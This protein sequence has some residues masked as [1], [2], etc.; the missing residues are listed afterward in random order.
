MTTL[1]IGAAEGA[2]AGLSNVWDTVGASLDTARTAIDGVDLKVTY[3]SD[4]GDQVHAGFSAVSASFQALLKGGVD[5]AKEGAE[6]LR[7]IEADFNQVNNAAVDNLTGL[8]PG[9]GGGGFGGGGLPLDAP[10]ATP[11]LPSLEPEMQTPGEGGPGEGDGVGE[12]AAL[13]VEAIDP[14]ELTPEQLEAYNNSLARDEAHGQTISTVEELLA[15]NL[16]TNTLSEGGGSAI[17]IKQVWNPQS[18]GY[19]WIASLPSVDMWAGGVPTEGLTLTPEA[20]AQYEQA[21][22]QALRDAGVPEG[23]QVLFTG[24]GQ[25]AIM[26]AT[27]ACDPHVPFDCMGV[28]ASGAPLDGF[29]FPADLPVVDLGVDGVAVDAAAPTAD[30]ATLSWEAWTQSG[31]PNPPAPAPMEAPSSWFGNITSHQM[32][33]WPDPT[34]N[35]TPVAAAPLV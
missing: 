22:C 25:G 19:H 13:P 2:L 18:G 15:Q 16:D 10:L 9:G 14:D 8:T 26:A 35:A 34:G 12:A 4:W 30:P 21:V 11:E 29:A 28:M 32:F 6:A 33:T 5:A 3:F 1:P 20:Q 17:D 23:G 7:K 27:L 31:D 24:T